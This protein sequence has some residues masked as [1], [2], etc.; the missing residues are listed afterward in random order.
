MKR[1]FMWMSIEKHESS[2]E[3]PPPMVSLTPLKILLFFSSQ[4]SHR[5]EGTPTSHK[6]T[7]LLTKV[8][9]NF[10]TMEW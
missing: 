1:V 8:V 6:K 5:V 9:I 7:S 2:K 3:T 10:L 4:M